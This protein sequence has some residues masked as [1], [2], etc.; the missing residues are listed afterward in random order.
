MKQGQETERK[1]DRS[2]RGDE[3]REG[4]DDENHER[5]SSADFYQV[6]VFRLFL[7]Y[8]CYSNN[9]IYSV[10]FEFFSS[11]LCVILLHFTV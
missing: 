10:Q 7:F 8:V 9:R 4:A 11:F 6:S 1:Q 5:V 3:G 2:T